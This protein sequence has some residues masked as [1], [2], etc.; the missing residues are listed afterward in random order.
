M[1][2]VTLTESLAF[3]RDWPSPAP[4]PGQV[5]VRVLS[6]GICNTDLELIRGYMGFRGVLGHEFVG[7]VVDGDPAWIGRRVVA[8][9]NVSCGA[10][11][12]CDRGF[13]TQ[14]RN[15]VTVGLDRHD[16]AMADFFA[17][18]AANLHAVP[19]SVSDV[20]AVF[21]EPL[22]AALQTL[23]CQPISPHDNVVIVGAGKLGLLMAQVVALTGAHVI[24]VVRRQSLADLLTGWGI[25]PAAYDDLPK[26]RADVVIDCTGTP[27]GFASSL[28][29]V[30]PRGTIHLKS[31]YAGLPETDLT[32]LVVDEIRL[33]GSRCGPFEAALRMLESGRVDVEPLIEARYPLDD[34]LAAF[35]HA[36]RPGALKIVLDMRDQA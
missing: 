20:H 34:A 12:L 22:A 26:K 25:E 17:I 23:E 24:S 15:R 18:S 32:R 8:E 30:R 11:D 36:S 1:R 9:I 5:L 2:A 28:D 21:A 6:A 4:Q 10:C 31:T 33:I 14:C 27:D 13:R 3:T 7:E 35:E 19:D 16:G 29:L